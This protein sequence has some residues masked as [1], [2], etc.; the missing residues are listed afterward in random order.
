MILKIGFLSFW[1]GGDIEQFKERAFFS[2]LNNNGIRYMEV[3]P[4]EAECHVVFVGVFGVPD[5]VGLKGNPVLISVR[6]EPR[7]WF[8]NNERL[9]SYHI[10]FE[11]DSENSLY[12]PLW[13]PYANDALLYRSDGI[14]LDGKTGLCSFMFSNPN[15]ERRN[16]VFRYLSENYKKVDSIGR[17]MNNVGFIIPRGDFSYPKK[18][19]FNICFE[20]SS[21]SS[22]YRYITEK[23]I[24][25]YAYDSIPVY[26]GNDC[27]GEYF[28]EK[29]F[30]NC[31]G[32]ANE[33]ILER[34]K[35]ID[36][37]DGLYLE[38]VN[39]DAKPLLKK[40]ILEYG[41]K[42]VEFVSRVLF[43]AKGIVL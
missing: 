37:N 3:N 18:Y 40:H 32:L 23:I 6:T 16:E 35:E 11:P 31:N 8:D 2:P 22:D 7:G 21:S 20:N 38:M 28:D 1:E 13:V 24:C 42:F 15:C 5:I 25:A 34:V 27:I 39:Y 30:I 19:K 10:G 12:Y 4:Y 36:N 26:W 33:E 9:C 29:S 14:G 43:I 41:L 17:W